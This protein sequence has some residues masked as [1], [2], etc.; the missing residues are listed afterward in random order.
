MHLRLIGVGIR[1]ICCGALLAMLCTVQA[2]ASFLAEP[3]MQSETVV[4][5][6]PPQPDTQ[7]LTRRAI[8]AAQ[9]A[10]G[11]VVVARRKDPAL[12]ARALALLDAFVDHRPLQR[13]G[14]TL[15]SDD[16]TMPAGGDGVWLATAWGM[17]GIVEMLD[18]LGDQVPAQLRAR[19][20]LLLREEVMRICEDWADR[21]PWFV[22]VH[23][24]VSNQWLEPSLALVQACLHLKDPRLAPC[25]DLGVE[26]IA[27]MLAPPWR[28]ARTAPCGWRS[29]PGPMRS[30][31]P[32]VI[33]SSRSRSWASR[34][35]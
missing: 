2:A 22:R 30:A 6:T 3:I 14:S 24:P 11:A 4:P 7:V 15:S 16:M 9:R 19:L 25:Y 27:Q 18:L 8:D 20:D 28:C 31:R 35:G 10:I 21:R 17:S 29:N 32:S 26:N 34:M 33:R 23:T 5:T 13:P 1:S 12:L